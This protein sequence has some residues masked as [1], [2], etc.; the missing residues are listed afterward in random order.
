M[1]ARQAS[2]VGNV[3]IL[4]GDDDADIEILEFARK[5]R[6]IGEVT[7]GQAQDGGDATGERGD[8]GPLH[9]TRPGRRIRDG[10]DDEQLI[11]IGDDDAFVGV[12]IV[13]G[14]SEDRAPIRQLHDT[15]E[16]PRF[17]RRVADNAH[18]VTHDDGCS[19]EFTGPH[20]HDGA[21]VVGS[22]GLVVQDNSPPTAVFGDDHAP[23][24]ILVGGAVFRAR[25][26]AFTWADVDI[27]F[28]PGA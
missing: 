14:A 10:R 8:Q 28:I 7:L 19:A 13:R 20:A 16:S 1:P 15:R 21:S 2:D 12:V 11:G 22:V 27:A 26:G 24:R 23:L 18:T 4:S 25:P 3:V 5:R 17:S 9:E 6:G